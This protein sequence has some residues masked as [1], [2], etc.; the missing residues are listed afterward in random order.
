MNGIV[1]ISK[2]VKTPL[3]LAQKTVTYSNSA[4]IHFPMFVLGTNLQCISALL[5]PV[6][7]QQFTGRPPNQLSMNE[8]K[9][10][11]QNKASYLVVH[12]TCW[13]EDTEE[14]RRKTQKG[15]QQT[16]EAYRAKDRRSILHQVKQALKH[17]SRI[18][19]R[20]H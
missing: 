14:N 6:A 11:S 5:G 12:F 19:I 10:E 15:I 1:G 4:K 3:T 16:R 8:L 17:T 13:G 20:S 9:S 18:K 2:G 7:R